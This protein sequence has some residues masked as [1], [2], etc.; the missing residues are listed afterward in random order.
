MEHHT[1]TLG[2]LGVLKAQLDLFEKGFIVSVPLTE[3][4]PFDLVIYKDGVCKTVQVKSRSVTSRGTIEIQFRNVWSD[5]NGIHSSEVDKNAID[6][7]C[8]YCP[9][10]DLCYYF[11]PSNF[12]KSITLRIEPPKNN[13]LTGVHLASDYTAL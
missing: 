4:A 2:D 10:T 1:K 5:R 8:V 3:H 12:D 6:L 13:Q 7:Y 9:E 11:N